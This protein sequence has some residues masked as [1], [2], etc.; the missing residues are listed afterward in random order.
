MLELDSDMIFEINKN[1]FHLFAKSVL[2]DS[3]IKAD[4]I[5]EDLYYQNNLTISEVDPQSEAFN[6]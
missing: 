4:W 1:L 6:L 2:D 3:Q 5:F